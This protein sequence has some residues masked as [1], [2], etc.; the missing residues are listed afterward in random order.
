M[1]NQSLSLGDKKLPMYS[2]NRASTNLY[3]HLWAIDENLKNVKCE[4]QLMTIQVENVIKF[5]L[6]YV[7]LYVYV[8]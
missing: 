1:N 5:D 6:R 7:L 3:V 2:V 8:G 4:L